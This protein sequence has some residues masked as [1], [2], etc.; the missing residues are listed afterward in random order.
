LRFDDQGG[1]KRRY[2]ELIRKA[3]DRFDAHLQCL[4]LGTTAEMLRVGRRAALPPPG[5]GR[6]AFGT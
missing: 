1:E 5:E 6:R 2:R 3:D 4:K